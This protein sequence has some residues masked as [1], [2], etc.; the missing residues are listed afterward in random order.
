MP[1]KQS[2]RLLP[3]SGHQGARNGR[4]DEAVLGIPPGRG[5]MEPKDLARLS[6]PQLH[7][8]QVGE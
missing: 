6:V 8:E 1:D 4:G 2:G 5:Q 3:V 7:G